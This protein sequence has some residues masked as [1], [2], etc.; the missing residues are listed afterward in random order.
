[1]TASGR[2]V[3]AINDLNDELNAAVN[4]LFAL[5]GLVGVTIVCLIALA[6]PVPAPIHR[7]SHIGEMLNRGGQ[8]TVTAVV[9]LI[10]MRAGQV[11]GILRRSLMIRH[12]IAID[13]AAKKTAEN[14]QKIPPM[15][16]LFGRHPDFGKTVNLEDLQDPEK[17]H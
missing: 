8:A 4:A 3:K 6:I 14:A 12:R 7:L 5:F 16:E 9:A 10:L 11:P 2:S 17:R 15:K 1:M 13:E